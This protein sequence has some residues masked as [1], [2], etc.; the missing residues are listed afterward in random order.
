MVGVVNRASKL[1]SEKVL[2]VRARKWFGYGRGTDLKEPS[3]RPASEKLPRRW[4]T[5]RTFA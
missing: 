5:E 4:V 1:P 3:E 2:R